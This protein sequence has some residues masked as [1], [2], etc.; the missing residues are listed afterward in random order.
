MGVS[1]TLIQAGKHKTEG[2]PF[3]PLDDEAREFIQSRVDDFYRIFTRDVAKGRGVSVS[4]ARGARFGDGR[5]LGAEAA[6]AA[7]MVDRVERFAQTIERMQ[8]QAGSGRR[9]ARTS[10]AR[11]RLALS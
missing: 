9:R 10:H 11:K 4:D 7:G 3:G 5:M 1:V 6:K 2:H 8:A